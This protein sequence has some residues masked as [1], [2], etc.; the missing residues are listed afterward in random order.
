[1]I[2]TSSYFI[3]LALMALAA[4][5]D[6]RYMIIPN[7]ISIAL[8]FVYCVTSFLSDLSL[9]TFAIQIGCGGLALVIG[10]MLFSLRL[11]GGGDVKLLAASMVWIGSDRAILFF[12]FMSLFGAMVAI[13]KGL[14]VLAQNRGLTLRERIASVMKTPVPYGVAIALAFAVTYPLPPNFY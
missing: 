5:F 13:V 4:Y 11:I 12:V 3:V 9:L 2:E 10:Y 14:F 7:W 6:F 1:M 8:V